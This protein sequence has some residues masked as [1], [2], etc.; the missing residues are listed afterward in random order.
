MPQSTQFSP[1]PRPFLDSPVVEIPSASNGT[2]P[3]RARNP[4]VPNKQRDIAQAVDSHRDP[5]STGRN[6]SNNGEEGQD[7][8]DTLYLLQS[9]TSQFERE[10]QELSV[11]TQP[12]QLST[13][14]RRRLEETRRT[15]SLISLSSSPPPPYFTHVS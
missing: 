3:R 15:T 5:L 14:D 8:G 7:F 6:L 13:E 1:R 11:V 9:S 2:T 4:P 10:A 12:G